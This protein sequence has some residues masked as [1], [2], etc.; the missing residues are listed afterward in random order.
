RALT[1]FSKLIEFHA[2]TDEAVEA[3]MRS[4]LIHL[5]LKNFASAQLQF[6]KLLAQKRDRFDLQGRYWLVR[7]LENTD[8][9]RFAVEA[10][11]LMDRYPFSYY[12]LRLNAELN[13]GEYT[14]P[15][16]SV[17]V[18]AGSGD[19]WLV[20]DQVK[21]WNR[22]KVLTK[23]GWLLEA[24]SEVQGLPLSKNPYLEYQYAKYMS[25]NNQYP[26][27]IRAMNDAMD[28]ENSLRAPES[29]SLVFPKNYSTW[30]EAESKKYNLNPILIRSLIRQES[31][32]GIRALSVSNAQGLMQ[33]I[34]GTAQDVARR[35]GMK[36]LDFPEDVFR[37]EINIPLG[38]FYISSMIDQF[39]GNVPFALAAYNAGP[40]KMKIFAEARE[41]I[42]TAR[43]KPTSSPLDEIWFDELPWSETSF[44]IKA[45]LRNSLLYKLI[46]AAKIDWTLV[47]WQDLHSKK[48]TL[49]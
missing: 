27:A 33:L 45:I 38:T 41:E 11:I 39:G 25:L 36:K 16:A 22:F 3:L 9:E 40:T 49:K 17:V 18:P 12:G 7:T 35:L 2:G 32:F 13:K 1:H 47:L 30:I 42:R 15:Q 29:L 28:L 31:A 43:D 44:Y 26:A 6:E 8:K 46:D 4:G 19:M 48:P 5:R 14:W 24:Q 20:G 37:P 10:K 23:A 34:P 21:A